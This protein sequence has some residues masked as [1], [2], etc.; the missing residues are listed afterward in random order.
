MRNSY[1]EVWKKCGPFDMLNCNVT[2]GTTNLDGSFSV[3]VD[4]GDCT[5]W[6]TAYTTIPNVV[7]VRCPELQESSANC[8]PT[9]GQSRNLHYDFQ[10]VYIK[11]GDS[12]DYGK[13]V[14]PSSIPA[15]EGARIADTIL[16]G[17]LS[18]KNYT[19]FSIPEVSV[20]FPCGTFCPKGVYFDPHT[21]GDIYVK[22]NLDAHTIVHGY[23][24]FLLWYHTT[25]LS[26]EELSSLL[27]KSL[28]QNI[29]GQEITL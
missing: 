22:Q 13:Q 4:D 12:F 29:Q 14:L 19:G 17:W 5:C 9:L 7:N 2:K 28:T 18:V 3:G 21:M 24:Q 20:E 6:V 23:F 25:N 27:D 1:F 15:A 26:E 10:S 16:T 8:Q 11:D